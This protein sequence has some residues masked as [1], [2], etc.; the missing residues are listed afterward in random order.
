MD[1]KR[2]FLYAIVIAALT[3]AGCGGNGGTK[4]VTPVGPTPP[5]SCPAGQTGTP[6]NCVTPGPSVADLFAT[7]QTQRTAAAAAEMTA[8]DSVKNATKY[9]GML[10]VLKV[11]GNS[12]KAR[13]NAQ[14]VLDAKTATAGAVTTAEKAVASLKQADT[15][16]DKHNNDALDGAIAAAL[17][18]AEDAVAAAKKESG[19]DALKTAVEAVTGTDTK[20]MKTPADAQKA[21]ATAIGGALM[22]STAGDAIS[23]IPIR[24]THRTEAGAADGTNTVASVRATTAPPNTDKTN[25]VPMVDLNDHQGRTW[26]Q[27]VGSSKTM[28]KTV[29]INSEGNFADTGGTRTKSVKAMSVSGMKVTSTATVGSNDTPL[30]AN[31][32]QVFTGDATN[33]YK[34]IPGMFF[35]QGNDCKVAAVSGAGNAGLR[36]LTGSW[37]FTPTSSTN[38]YVTDATDSKKYMKEDAYVQYGH[39]LA[40]TNASAT[41]YTF[42]YTTEGTA[43]NTDYNITTVNSGTGAILS[44]SSATYTGHAAGMSLHKQINSDGGAVKG[45]EQ[46][47][48]FTADVTLTANFGASPTLGGTI[49]NFRAGSLDMNGNLENVNMDAVDTGW[50]VTLQNRSFTGGAFLATDAAS[51]GLAVASGQNG[52]W[53]AQAYGTAG[54][55]TVDGNNVPVTTGGTAT[56]SVRPEGIFGKFNAHFSD[57][58]AAGAY[59]TRKQ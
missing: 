16:A 34:G 51:S 9:S 33:A 40:G 37:Y 32:T 20:K 57:G 39:W 19:S 4:T 49:S 35:C 59:A 52:V 28:D 36:T 58:H 13:D 10:D 55:T 31:G 26:A 1:M 27:I 17:K 38:W 5:P 2:F 15:D 56:L 30:T 23:G 21:V 3:L 8:K 41:I 22:A 46:S 54:M 29:F 44:D 42:A 48:P 7:A 47:G 24:V 43:N 25:D 11:M 45:T 50:R 12:M 18:V 14:A 6:P 53:T